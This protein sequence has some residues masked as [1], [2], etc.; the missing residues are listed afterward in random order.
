MFEKKKSM[1]FLKRYFEKWRTKSVFSKIT[2]VL[3]VMLIVSIIIPATRI[4][5]F[6]FASRIRTLIVKPGRTDA[7]TQIQLSEADYQWIIVNDKGERFPLENMKGKVLFINFWATWCPPCI[8]EMPTIQD[9][10]EHYKSNPDIA[11]LMFTTDDVAKAK[12]FMQRKKYT[13]PL[14]FAG[15]TVPQNIASSSIPAT[16]VISK[17]GRI[18]INEVGAADWN[19]EKVRNIID[20]LLVK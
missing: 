18:E 19:S 16:F 11:F 1:N 5:V 7:N 9:L 6:G 14:Y 4:E 8:G 12:E 15:S 10:Y 17:T 20:E 2:D 13:F 3:F